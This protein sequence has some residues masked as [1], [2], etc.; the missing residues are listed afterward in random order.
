MFQKPLSITI[1]PEIQKRIAGI[2]GLLA[3]TSAVFALAVYSNSQANQYLFPPKAAIQREDL[4]LIAQQD[5]ARYAL[6]SIWLNLVIGIGTIV[7]ALTVYRFSQRQWSEARSQARQELRA[8]VGIKSLTFH[9]GES[10]QAQFKV[11]CINEGQTPA[12]NITMSTSIMFLECSKAQEAYDETFKELDYTTFTLNPHAERSYF[13]HFRALT[14]RDWEKIR[15]GTHGF[16]VI[17]RVFYKDAFGMTWGYEMSGKHGPD[18]GGVGKNTNVLNWMPE[19]H[20][21]G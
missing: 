1:P 6:V 11:Q 21:I 10:N 17:V 20:F 7:I 2:V 15:P 12:Y 18:T 16:Y 19:R 5:M 3:I 8:Y 13:T 4:D 14:E 9:L